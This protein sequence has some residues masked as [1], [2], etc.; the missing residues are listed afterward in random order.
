MEANVPKIKVR[1]FASMREVFQEKEREIELERFSTIR[2][3]LKLL[4]NTYEQRQRIFDQSGKNRTDITI[5]KNG[6]HIQFLD[7]IETRLEEGDEIAIFPLIYG[8]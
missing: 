6:R 8:G 1:F 5:L 4:C 2:D 7:G 3:L